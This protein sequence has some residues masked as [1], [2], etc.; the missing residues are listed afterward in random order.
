MKFAEDW[1]HLDMKSK[2]LEYIVLIGGGTPKTSVPE[3]WGGDI[4]WLSVKDF[5][6]DSRYV[7]STEKKLL[8]R[9]WRI[10]QQSCLMWTT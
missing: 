6:D 8:K 10:A 1:G 7:Y 9:V 4:P 5:N 3:Y 2:L